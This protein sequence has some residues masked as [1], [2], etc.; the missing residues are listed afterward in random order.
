MTAFSEL[1][2]D[3]ARQVFLLYC[4][5]KGLAERTLQTYF[6]A[7]DGLKAFLAGPG[8]VQP[9]P[10][11]HELRSFVAHLLDQG[12]ARTTISIRMRAIR[13][14]CNFLA[15]EGIV[16]NSPMAGVA[17]PKVPSRYPEILTG[18][19]AKKLVSAATASNWASIRNRAMVL[20]LLDTGVRLGELIRLDLVDVQLRELTIRIRSGK[21]DKERYVFLGRSL[22]RAMRAWIEARGAFS[23]S[24]PLFMTR[25]GERLDGRNVQRI[26]SRLAKKA[27]LEGAKVSPH[28][29][30]HSFATFYVQNGGDPFSLQRIL[31][32]SDIKTTMI[33]VNLAGV[34]L[35]EAHAKASPVDRLLVRS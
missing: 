3:D 2:F 28:R 29:L 13:A 30:R 1:D 19:E 4:R 20:T 11:A 8:C 6:S 32:H 15:R 22:F 17:V 33:Y 16:P 34:G 18:A 9:L 25:W 12:L 23:Q 10:G 27:G 26:L 31:G 5:S 21:G 24:G 35:R 14:F 7:I